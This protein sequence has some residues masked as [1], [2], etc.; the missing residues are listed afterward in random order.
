MFPRVFNFCF[1]EFDNK[2]HATAALHHLQVARPTSA[3][4]T[5][6]GLADS[7]TTGLQNGEKRCQGALNLLC[8]D[9]AQGAPYA[10]LIACRVLPFIHTGILFA[11]NRERWG[12]EIA[13]SG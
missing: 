2:Y 3:H 4:G 8:E 5:A 1:V 10:V 6:L 7:L 11:Y 9:P 13:P 12:E